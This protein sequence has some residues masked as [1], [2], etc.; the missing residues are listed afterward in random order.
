[1]SLNDFFSVCILEIEKCYWL[2]SPLRT[3]C[4][5]YFIKEALKYQDY[6]LKHSLTKEMN[7]WT[8]ERNALE[9]IAVP[10]LLQSVVANRMISTLRIVPLVMETKSSFIEIME[11]YIYIY[12]Y[13]YDR[14]LGP[15]SSTDS[16]RL[17]RSSGS[18]IFITETYKHFRLPES[19]KYSGSKSSALGEYEKNVRNS[20]IQLV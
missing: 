18:R 3:I 20:H 11:S 9:T 7:Y 2:Y 5:M 19:G 12:I 15:V 1:L 14:S 10:N 16:R 17:G 8:W 6:A 13:I 4:I